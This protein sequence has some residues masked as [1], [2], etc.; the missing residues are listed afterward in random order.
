M[1]YVVLALLAVLVLAPVVPTLYQSFLDRPLYEAGGLFTPGNYVHLFTDAGFGTVVSTPRCSP[2]AD[3]VLTLLIAVPMAVLVVRTKLPG[4][5]LFAG[6]CNG[7][8]SS[9][10]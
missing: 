2:S 5:R 10:R 7:R 8:S 6:P 9:P 3:H 4:G 1:Q